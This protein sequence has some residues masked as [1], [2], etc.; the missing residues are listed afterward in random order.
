VKVHG[1]GGAAACVTVNVLPAAAIVAV[2]EL[3]FVLAATVNLTWPLP[4][5]ELPAVMLIHGAVVVAV[6]AQLFADTVTEIELDPPA[7]A[8]LRVVG[9]IENEHAGG[10]AA[11]W[12]IVNVFPATVIV[13]LRAGPAFAATRYSIE[14]SPLPDPPDV[15]VS[16]LASPVATHAQSDPVVT[17]IVPVELSEPTLLLVGE[18][19]YT[20]GPG[21]GIGVGVGAGAGMGSGLPVDAVC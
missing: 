18:M 21:V 10:G 1:G 17:R 19:V 12:A 15:M 20:Q 5:P 6:H 8:K 3:L 2:R 9:E 4:V 7:A 16:Q 11:A 14:P 13:A